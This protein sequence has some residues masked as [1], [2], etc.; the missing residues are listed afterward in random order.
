MQCPACRYE[1]TLAEVQRSPGSCVKCGVNYEEFQAKADRAREERLEIQRYHAS[2]SAKPAAVRDAEER[3]PGAQPVVVVD[4]NMSF[5][6]MVRFM[7]K[8]AIA[9]IPALIILCIIGSGMLSILSLIF[10]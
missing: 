4:V 3:Y 9:A 1:P 7:V 6:S 5:V 2:R 10:S 8:W